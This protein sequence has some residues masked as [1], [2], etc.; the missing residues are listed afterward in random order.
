MIPT[1]IIFQVKQIPITEYLE[2]IGY[3]PVR[4]VGKQ[5]VYTSPLSHERTA[6]F[7]VEPD[8]N[9]FNDFSGNEKGDIIRLV[10]L[11]NNC[12]FQEAIKLLESFSSCAPTNSFSFSGNSLTHSKFSIRKIKRLENKVLM[13]YLLDRKISYAIA[14][15]YLLEAY[16]EVNRKQYFALCFA[17]DKG[18]Y[19]LR[20]SIYKGCTRPKTITT[21]PVYNSKQLNLFEGFFDF[22]SALEYFKTYSP[23]HTTIVLNSLSLLSDT[24]PLLKTYNQI[25]SYL[26]NDQAGNNALNTLLNSNLKVINRS[27]IYAG[28]KDFNTFLQKR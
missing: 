28:N 26:D 17:N 22:L 8:K 25:N 7:F 4:S 9:V 6:S 1:D 20:N 3:L 5:L 16:F 2:S 27:Y 14:R 11:I 13:N 12:T 19:E 24:L 21:I 23:N 15:N 18:G 10:R